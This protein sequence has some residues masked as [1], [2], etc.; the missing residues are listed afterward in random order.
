MV[1]RL[2]PYTQ[3]VIDRMADSSLLDAVDVTSLRRPPRSE[4]LH[5]S[6][7]LRRLH[8]HPNEAKVA[9][10]SEED[11][12]KAAAQLALY[13]L[14]GLAFEDR[15]ELALRALAKDTDWPWHAVR[16]GEVSA[17]GLA[18]SPDILL[19][20]KHASERPREL[21]IKTTW[22]TCGHTPMEEGENEFPKEFNYYIAQCKTYAEPLETVGSVLVC[23]FVCGTWK[24]PV[25]VVLGWELEFNEV[26][27][28]ENW[29]AVM[30]VA[31]EL[32]M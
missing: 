24:P 26:E 14:L 12:A 13:G 32:E 29:A 3:R 7:V 11:K 16:P 17:G 9:K 2:W 31:S 18:C 5:A 27:L 19:V 15:C 28:A 25:P 23:Y 10:M 6:T 22:K 30:Q 1:H 8:P 4:G 20:P 21:S